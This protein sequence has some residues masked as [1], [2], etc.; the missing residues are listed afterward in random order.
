MW[1]WIINSDIRTMLKHESKHKFKF[2]I[3]IYLIISGTYN[4]K[5]CRCP[6]LSVI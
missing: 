4:F 5:G 1:G 6:L 3:S 2:S